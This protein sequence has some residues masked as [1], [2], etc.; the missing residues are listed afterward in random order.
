MNAGGMMRQL[1]NAGYYTLASLLG[2]NLALG[3]TAGEQ[4]KTD[5]G[6]V[7]G[8]TASSGIRIFRGIPFAAPPTGELRWKAPQPVKSWTGVRPATGFGANCMQ[9]QVFGDMGFRSNGASEDCLY[10]NV[11]TPA[12]SASEK[13]PVL[14]Y[15]YGGGF[16]AGDGSEPRYDGEA[17]A[18]KG[19]IAVT[20][21]Y[22]LG[23]FGFL[24]HPEL[25]KESPQHASGNYALL[26]QVATIRWVYDNIAALGGDRKKI[27][28]AGESAGSIAVSALM[29]SPLSRGM[30]AGAIGSS[31]SMMG[32]LP[33]VPLAEG[34]QTGVKFATSM[35][36]DSLAA[37]RA[38]PANELL[39]MTGK[40]GVP[41]FPPT[42]D[43]YFLPRTPLEIFQAGEQAHVPLL[44]GWNSEEQNARIFLGQADPTPEN[45]AK[46]VKDAYG[47]RAAEILKLFPGG[48]PQEV[49][50]SGTALA[51]ARFTGY[52]SWKWVELQ[53]KTGGK[54][55]YRYFYSHP[56]PAMRPEMGDA[57]AG[58][59]GG[60]VRG[61]RGA[62]PRLAATGAV[63][64]SD[65]DYAM[66]NLDRSKVH[67]WT[68]ED[69]KI[70]DTFLGYYANF[71]LTGNPNGSGLPKWPEVK[72]GDAAP[73]LLHID[74]ETKAEP[75]IYRGRWLLL[76]QINSKNPPNPSPER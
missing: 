55:V 52:S 30:I 62:T 53:A 54:P 47:D 15:F 74:V 12:K 51:S 27:T 42:V 33:A 25:T 11:W 29:A 43:G 18:R 5:K 64:S 28:I 72:S 76:D 14:I 20:S 40:P 70:S 61:G 22:R 7:E 58:L 65:I 75:D 69:H 37:L 16:Q 17:I 19:V 8:I 63:H 68:A 26:D 50:E 3:A 73:Q 71:V 35:G 41:R 36:K 60:V 9:R 39:A 6:V 56:R 24:A 13:L 10:L 66:G 57:V 46:A 2:I 34:E 67:A 44:M 21:N 49:I 45:Y 59:A 32:T 38:I 23:V 4:V 1:R 48:T 31:G